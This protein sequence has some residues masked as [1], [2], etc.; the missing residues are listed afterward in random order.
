MAD[1][2]FARLSSVFPLPLSSLHPPYLSSLPP[3][4]LSSVPLF[5]RTYPSGRT[6]ECVRAFLD[7]EEFSAK[8]QVAALNLIAEAEA[9]GFQKPDGFE[10]RWGLA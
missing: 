2:P 1:F 10:A 5:L 7:P 3:P 8:K 9:A 6:Q 4:Y